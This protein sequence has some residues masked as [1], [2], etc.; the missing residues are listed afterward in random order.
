MVNPRHDRIGGLP[1]YPSVA[2]IPGPV[3]TALLIVPKTRVADT[4]AD[5]GAKGVKVATI[6]SSGFAETG[7]AGLAEER[8]L[9]ALAA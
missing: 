3:D 7:A 9:V 8:A 2:A 1:C 4:L 5:C 6:I